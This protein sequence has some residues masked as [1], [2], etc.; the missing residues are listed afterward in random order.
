MKGLPK[1]KKDP[2]SQTAQHAAQTIIFDECNYQTWF[3]GNEIMENV[4]TYVPFM[5]CEL[6]HDTTNEYAAQSA[7]PPTGNQP[8]TS[9]STT[10]RKLKI[11][12]FKKIRSGE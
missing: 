10:N 4:C 11:P 2:E 1:K 7:Q 5:T 8:S 9:Q 12:P 6:V 3:R